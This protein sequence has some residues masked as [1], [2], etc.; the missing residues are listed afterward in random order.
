MSRFQ[1]RPAP[2]PV[3]PG[4]KASGHCR[5][6]VQEALKGCGYPHQQ[7]VKA[8]T[9]VIFPRAGPT[10]FS[11][12]EQVFVPLT[13]GQILAVHGNLPVK[14]GKRTI[15]PESNATGHEQ[16]ADALSQ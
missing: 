5:H 1:H 9:D 15:A 6:E 3:F 14:S 11:G 7:A 16:L 4:D 8:S 13:T 2:G 12:L 10:L